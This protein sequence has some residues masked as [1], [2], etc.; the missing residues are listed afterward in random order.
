MSEE[1]FSNLS[2]I[3]LLLD[4]ESSIDI[5]SNK[6]M[7]SNTRK[8]P[9]LITIH[10]NVGSRQVEHTAV[11]NGYGILWY[12]P[13]AIANILS[14]SRAT[15]KYRVVFHS[16][17]RNCFMMM[18]TERE[19][20]FNVST[21]SFYYHGTVDRAIVIVD[22]VE[23]NHEVFTRRYYEG[24]KAVRRAL[25]LMGFPVGVGLY[26]HYEFQHDS[27]LP[28]HASRYQKS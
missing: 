10:C 2:P 23:E 20:V 4:S 15:R 1:K 25:G 26:Q 17:S 6:A 22:T 11:L 28:C 14:L 8:S 19:V 21:N 13:K 5:F 12:D 9:S 16:E 24:A 3:W 27:K 18:L 7:V